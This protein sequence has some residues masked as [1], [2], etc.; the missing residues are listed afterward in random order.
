MR[1]AERIAAIRESA[2]LLSQQSWND[3]DL[4]LGQHGIRTSQDW[5]GEDHYGYV[6]HMIQDASDDGLHELHQYLVGE[7]GD[8][9]TGGQPWGQGQLKL[10]MSHLMPNVLITRPSNASRGANVARPANPARGTI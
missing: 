4:I 5:Q 8:V 2:T 10:F 6:V 7:T 9:P 1:P 3:I